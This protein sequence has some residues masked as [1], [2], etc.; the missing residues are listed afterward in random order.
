M[1]GEGLGAPEVATAPGVG[2]DADPV[3]SAAVV[4]GIALA[5]NGPPEALGRLGA[6]HPMLH[7]SRAAMA[8]RVL[9]DD[10]EI[11]GRRA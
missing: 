11:G 2:S 1:S 8:D 9:R 5:G 3:L 4:V 10:N 7:V 6:V